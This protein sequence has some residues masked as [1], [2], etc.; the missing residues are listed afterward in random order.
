MGKENRTSGAGAGAL[1]EKVKWDQPGFLLS[2]GDLKAAD[3]HCESIV[4]Q[5]TGKVL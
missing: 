4:R 1:L 2:K 5:C 3:E